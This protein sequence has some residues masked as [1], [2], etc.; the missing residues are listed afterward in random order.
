MIESHNSRNLNFT[1]ALNQFADLTMAEF[2][3][4]YLTE[5]APLRSDRNFVKST[6]TDVP[7]E[8][9]WTDEGDV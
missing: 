1:M 3:A 4:M 2:K 7:A 9:N 8:K 6:L 5:L